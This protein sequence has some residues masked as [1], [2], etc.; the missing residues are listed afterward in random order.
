LR[1]GAERPS[2]R[3]N[4]HR[5][6]YHSERIAVEGLTLAA[7]QPLI[8]VADVYSTT[9]MTAA[10]TANC[11]ENRNGCL[12]FVTL[13]NSR[14]MPQVTLIGVCCLVLVISAFGQESTPAV[15][16]A[17]PR[18]T[19]AAT[20]KGHAFEVVSIKPDRSGTSGGGTRLPDGFRDTGVVFATLVR[21]A[22]DVGE[23]Q[24]VGMP[25][26]AK[27]DPYNVEARVDSDNAEQWKKLTRKERAVQE[28]PMLQIMLADRCRLKVH[29]ETKEMPVYDLVIAKGGLK[30]KEAAPNE[31]T[32]EGVSGGRLTGQRLTARAQATDNLLAIIS[33]TDGRLVVDKTG[34]GEKRFDFDLKWTP[35]DANTTPDSGPLLFTALEE[36]FGLKLVPSEG[37]V[38]VLVI[39][40]MERPSSN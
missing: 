22:Y 1:T 21:D 25:A 40:H 5:L 32:P 36:Q 31:Q 28:R 23:Y 19:Q 13:Y 16:S 39:E 17:Q 8:K 12:N 11:G 38:N 20:D 29:Q 34:L 3:T 27:S 35:E 15:T 6:R 2:P 26:W 4:H 30:M 9:E 14:V 24:V 33:G 10:S 18:P 37:L 7:R